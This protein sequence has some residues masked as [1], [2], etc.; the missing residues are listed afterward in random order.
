MLRTKTK[1]QD[2]GPR[3][4]DQ[5]GPSPGL[6]E[7]PIRAVKLSLSQPPL[8]KSMFYRSSQ[9]P[10]SIYKVKI[11]FIRGQRWDFRSIFENFE[12]FKI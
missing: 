11:G 3:T 7:H 5:Y 9:V 12:I 1:D 8:K 10:G 2:Q 6:N 4:K